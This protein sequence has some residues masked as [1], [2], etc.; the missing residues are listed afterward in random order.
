MSLKAALRVQN[1][2]PDN[3]PSEE[4]IRQACLDDC[5]V[6]YD[7]YEEWWETYSSG[8]SRLL[9]KIL[10]EDYVGHRITWEDYEEVYE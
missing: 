3:W 2:R 10:I 5:R 6:K 9:R 7:S 8:M 1:M 4:W